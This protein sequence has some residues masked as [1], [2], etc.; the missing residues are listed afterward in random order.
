MMIAPMVFLEPN[1][2]GGVLVYAFAAS[3]MGGMTSPFGAVVGGFLIGVIENLIGAFVPGVGNEI[4]FP[5][6]LALIIIVLVIRPDGLFGR[7]VVKR[8]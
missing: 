8:V 7:T 4:K 6:A 1:M 2:M 5:L 3:V